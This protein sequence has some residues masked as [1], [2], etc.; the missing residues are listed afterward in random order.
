[1]YIIAPSLLVAISALVGAVTL[2]SIFLRRR[3]NPLVAFVSGGVAAGAGSL[4]FMAPLNF[5][6]FE[7]ERT[8]WDVG[9]GLGL[10]VASAGGT[11]WIVHWILDRRRRGEGVIPEAESHPGAFNSRQSWSTAALCLLPTVGLLLVFSYIPMVNTFRLSTLLARFGTSRTAFRCV[12]NFSRLATDADYLSILGLSLFLAAAIVVVG[13]SFA[14]IVASMAS[15][16]LRGARVYRTLLIWPY[17]VSPIIAGQLFE[18]LLAREVGVV[19]TVLSL[20]V[21]WL[22]EVNWARFSL[23]VASVWNVIGF[24]I[25][26]YIAGLQ[27]V[28]DDVLEAASIDGANAMQRF[29]FITFPLLSPFTFFLVVTNTIYALFDTFG[30]ID[31][32]TEGGPLRSTY[33]AM[34]NVF[35]IGIEGQD[36]GKSTAQSLVLL[37][38]VVVITIIQFRVSRDR[39]NYAS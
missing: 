22:V 21:P 24:N 15:L 12:D 11:T 2:G 13:L 23:I 33:T 27:N 4:I 28:P 5:C 36:L 35:K 3:G 19:N 30:M 32:L 26:F 37:I 25:L 39:I 38:I 9:I 1:M 20:D 18:M 17:A 10:I 16:P 31:V 7:V 14:L 8:A 34:Y 6:T 29:F